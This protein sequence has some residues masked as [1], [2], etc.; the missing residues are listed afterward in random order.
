MKRITI[1]SVAVVLLLC[2]T[3]SGAAQQIYNGQINISSTGLKQEG[4]NLLL[5]MLVDM[6]NVTVDKNRALT[7]TPVL[8]GNN[9]SMDL[10]EILINGSTRQKS[11]NRA[12]ALSGNTFQSQP[13]A[14]LRSGTDTKDALLYT[15]TIPYERW[16]ADAHLEMKQDLCGCGGNEQVVAQDRIID[17]V[18]LED[19]PVQVIQPAVAYIQPSV[20]TVKS[21]NEKKE[22]FLNFPVGKTDILADYMNNKSELEKVSNILK[23]ISSDKN[24]DI[25][26]VAIVGYASP[27]GALK[28]NESLS[29]GRA[30]ALKKYLSSDINN[31]PANNINVEYGGENWSGL[32]SM[33]EASQMDGKSEVLAILNNTNDVAVRKE[34]LK[35]LNG[36]KPYQYMLSEF[37]P[38][39]RKADC[40]ILYNIR[41]FSVDEGKQILKTRP[42]QLSMNE[43][44]QIAN[45]YPIGSDEFV[46]VFETAVHLFP[47]DKVANLN[48]AAAALSRNDLVSAKKYLDKSADDTSEYTNNLGVYNMLSGNTEE[49]RILFTK[50]QQRGSS[51]AR[52]NII[53]LDNVSNVK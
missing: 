21:R 45:S 28:L 39:L 32:V 44:Y 38:N 49:A 41:N 50:A 22:V 35:K 15:Q 34:Q 42:Q 46:N 29:M 13:Y 26:R 36:G 3:I 20:E 43:M 51:I 30:E 27:E 2:I 47:D 19:V 31:L 33:V 11:Y 5:S 16:M 53:E 6:S 14:T 25:T 8:V 52:Q 40:N 9:R 10:P 18:I 17:K 7:L 48:A 23:E 1:Y 4:D 24:L 37:Y 12:V